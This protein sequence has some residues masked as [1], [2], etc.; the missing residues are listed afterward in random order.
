METFLFSKLK[1]FRYERKFYLK[2]L[3]REEL[4]TILKFHPAAFKEIYYERTVNSIYFDSFDLHH[5]LDNVNGVTKRL[6]VRIRWYG[7]LLGFIEKPTLELKVKH[8]QH[9]G[10]LLYPL[11]PFTL[12]NNFSIDTIRNLFKKLS[13]PEVLKLHLIKL[14][15]SLLN[16]Y[17]RKYYLSSD[18]KYRLT[19]DKDV[20]V[21]KITPYHN[22]FL[23][24]SK[25]TEGT[26]LELKYNK[27]NDEFVDDITNYFSFRMTRS[28]KYVDG[29]T[30]LYV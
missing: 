4:E 16:S 6:K 14:N 21:Y 2:G 7:D 25:D 13:L 18:K 15:F 17:S 30:R 23:C 10:K 24:K 19:I 5:Y 29:I 1:H 8:N 11:G 28:S 26:I 20:E 12:D 9:V 3:K 27:P 22:N